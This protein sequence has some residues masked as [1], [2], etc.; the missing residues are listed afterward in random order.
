MSSP[1]QT[2]DPDQSVTDCLLLMT[3]RHIRHLPVLEQDVLTGMV[4]IGDLVQS[5]IS[6]Q[7][8][9]IDQFERYIRGAYPS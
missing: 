3:D 6:E 2:V 8:K 5:I 4:S 7:E 1:V 9:R